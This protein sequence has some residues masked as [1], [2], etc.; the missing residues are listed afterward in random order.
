MP[1]GSSGRV[2]SVPGD[3]YVLVNAGPLSCRGKKLAYDKPEFPNERAVI[4]E[5]RLFWRRAGL[6]QMWLERFVN[7]VCSCPWV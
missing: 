3:L 5:M 7:T 6:F 4:W 2:S 1:R